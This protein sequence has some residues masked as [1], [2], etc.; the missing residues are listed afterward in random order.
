LKEQLLIKK[1]IES[2]I[3]VFLA[4]FDL[5]WIFNGRRIIEEDQVL[6]T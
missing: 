5:A 4:V 6:S 3:S 2:K 1:I